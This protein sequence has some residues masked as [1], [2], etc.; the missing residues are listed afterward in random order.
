MIEVSNE[1][2]SGGRVVS[3][4]MEDELQTRVKG[5]GGPSPTRLF[6]Q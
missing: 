2:C 5:F 6:W 4:M 3:S 1:L